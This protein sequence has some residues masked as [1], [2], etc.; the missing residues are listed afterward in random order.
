M[1]WL[2][3]GNLLA[4]YAISTHVHHARVRAWFASLTDLFATCAITQ[5]TLLRLHMQLAVDTSA[6]AAWA[7]LHGITNHPRHQ[8]WDD[9]FSY[10]FVPIRQV[11]GH[12]QVTDAWLAQLARQHSGKVATLDQGLAITHADV[13]VLIP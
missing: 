1:T 13:A 2:L 4:A 12:R 11:Q 5:G 7:E 10:L 6:N 9:G 8:F 3:D